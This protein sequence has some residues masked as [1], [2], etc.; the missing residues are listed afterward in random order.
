MKPCDRGLDEKGDDRAQNEGTQEVAQQE[1]D[2]DCDRQHGEAEPDL[3][4]ATPALQ[5][6][7]VGGRRWGER[8]DRFEPRL[9]SRA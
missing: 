9:G 7:G 4:V 3:H 5:V 8:R 2:E 6:G 1:E